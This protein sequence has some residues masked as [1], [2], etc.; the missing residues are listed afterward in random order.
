MTEIVL[1]ASRMNTNESPELSDIHSWLS[2]ETAELLMA[3]YNSFKLPLVPE[4]WKLTS[5][6]PLF[7]TI[8][9]RLSKELHSCKFDVCTRQINR[10]CNRELN[11]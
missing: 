4:V 1:Q 9:T 3:L 10:Q 6:V 7:A 11:Q 2:R 5:M 8:S